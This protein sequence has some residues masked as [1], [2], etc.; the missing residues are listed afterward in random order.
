MHIEEGKTI[1]QDSISLEEILTC[2]DEVVNRENFSRLS[3]LYCNGK[4]VPFIGAG[5]SIPPYM[6]WSD[7][8]RKLLEDRDQTVRDELETL[9]TEQQF[10][11]A[12]DYVYIKLGKRVFED[13]FCSLYNHD[14]EK[15]NKS[16]KLIPILFN[17]KAILTTNYD[18][19]LDEAF[20][21]AKVDYQTIYPK[22]IS[23]TIETVDKMR[24]PTKTIIWKLHGD[25][26]MHSSRVFTSREYEKYYSE[27]IRKELGYFFSSTSFLFLGA[28]L[29]PY[30][31]YINILKYMSS[32]DRDLQNFAFL[33]VP[34]TQEEFENKRTFCSDIGVR[35]IWYPNKDSEH[36]SVRVLLR[37]LLYNV[38]SD[39]SLRGSATCEEFTTIDIAE[40]LKKQ[41]AAMGIE[42]V[43]PKEE[44]DDD[45]KTDYNK[46][47]TIDDIVALCL[48]K[49][50]Q[51]SK[52]GIEYG[53]YSALGDAY[54]AK[55]KNRS[56][57]KDVRGK[58]KV[59]I[60]C[61][62]TC[63]KT[64]GID[65]EDYYSS[66]V[67]V[68]GVG[69]GEEGMAFG[70]DKIAKKGSL[71]LVDIALASLRIARNRFIKD[72][73][74]CEIINQPAQDMTAVASDSKDIY[75]STMTYQSSFFNI[76]RAL[77]EALRVLKHD[78]K[79]IISVVNGYIDENSNYRQ[80]LTINTDTS[81]IPND[82]EKPLDTT[83][84]SKIVDK[85]CSKLKI[86]GFDH[87]SCF[88]SDAELF[89]CGALGRSTE[90]ANYEN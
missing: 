44:K 5:L 2:Q 69:N 68:V 79:I 43:I 19:C 82:K 67:I 15:Y 62:Y 20:K 60:D 58:D 40:R 11:A 21:E 48:A 71:C 24:N 61:F 86:L 90:T 81:K 39:N 64:L 32:Q 9:I 7:T 55:Y 73:G 80:G 41:L 25:Y 31:S 42:I 27:D 18:H 17:N 78:G 87:I 72:G 66:S 76:D 65:V 12:A 29:S 35:P 83:K 34:D 46:S 8:L 14:S 85:I 49:K 4:I 45:Q 38:T 59:W 51:Y 88:F 10:L 52:E 16:I 89:V 57:S 36:E 77:Y 50:S 74:S 84:P 54:D 37:R 6:R 47:I 70:Y 28:S 53:I 26:E 22:D 56:I 63:L 75:I 30:D 23:S 33:R 3:D 13:R 1:N